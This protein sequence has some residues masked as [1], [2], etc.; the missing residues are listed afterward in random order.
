MR[1]MGPEFVRMLAVVVWGCLLGACEP[2]TVDDAPSLAVSKAALVNT[3]YID[4]R[5]R[6]GTAV[7]QGSTCGARNEVTPSCKSNS[8]ASDFSFRWMAPYTGSFTYTTHGSNYDTVL[9]VTDWNS[10]ATLGCNDNAPGGSTSGVSVNL[11]AGQEVSITVDGAGWSCGKFQLNITGVQLSCGACNTPPSPCHEPNGTCSGTTCQYA[12][13]AEGASCDAGP[14]PDQCYE[15][16]GTCSAGQCVPNPK[17]AGTWCD[18]GNLCMVSACNGAGQCAFVENVVCPYSPCE[19]SYGCDPFQGCVYEDW[20]SNAGGICAY[21]CCRDA[22]FNY[23]IA[24]VA[25]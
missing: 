1:L 3:S 22:T 25:W 12:L 13:K 21:G 8:S 5:L 9:V 14:P 18:S 24:P 16:T 7:A 2:S 23:C 19:H 11:S 17:P 6:T 10:S 20:C 15:S 4:L